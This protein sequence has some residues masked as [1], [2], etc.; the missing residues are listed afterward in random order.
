MP[1]ETVDDDD[2]DE[3]EGVMGVVQG[4]DGRPRS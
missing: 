2:D 4:D 3:R 1:E